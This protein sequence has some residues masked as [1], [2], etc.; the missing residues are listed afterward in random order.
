MT[1]RIRPARELDIAD[2]MRVENACFLPGVRES[3]SV[4]RDRLAAFP[5]GNLVLEP[6]SG[7]APVAG[8][9]SSEIWSRVPPPEKESYELGHSALSRHDPAGTVL[10]VSSVAVHPDFRGGAG[11]SLFAG[12]LAEILAGYPGIRHIV[13]I[14]NETWLAARHI[15]ETEGF[16]YSGSIGGFFGPAGL[17]PQA[18]LIMEK[19]L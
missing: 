5:A 8:Y 12:A 14:V 1:Y 15:Y 2:I 6:E 11:R 18:A 13:F 7:D 9:F 16:R 3:E 17:P 10:Y 4:F 19:D